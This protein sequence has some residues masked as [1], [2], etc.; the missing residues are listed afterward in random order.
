M[1]LRSR[2][3]SQRFWL[4]VG[5]PVRK[6]SGISCSALAVFLVLTLRLLH[7]RLKMRFRRFRDFT[8]SNIKGELRNIQPMTLTLV[9]DSVLF[10]FPMFGKPEERDMSSKRRTKCTPLEP[11]DIGRFRSTHDCLQHGNCYCHCSVRPQ[12]FLLIVCLTSP[13]CCR[14]ILALYSFCVSSIQPSISMS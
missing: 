10:Y 4:P 13:C 11:R 6:L 12:S 8:I 14:I 9:R 7:L 1:H 3:G 5:P 2:P